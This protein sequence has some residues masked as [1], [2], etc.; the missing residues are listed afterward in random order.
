MLFYI[1]YSLYVMVLY[2][3]VLYVL[4]YILYVISQYM[5]IVMLRLVLREHIVSEK[6][7]QIA[8]ETIH[9]HLPMGNVIGR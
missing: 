9:R 2:V 6:L 3:M 8:I 5:Y 4:F 1:C 7:W